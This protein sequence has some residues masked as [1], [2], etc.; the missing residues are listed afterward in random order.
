VAARKH[1]SFAMISSLPDGADRMDHILG[2][3]SASRGCNRLTRW[4][5]TAFGTNAS[6]LIC[7]ERTSCP[8]N[9]TANPTA[10][11]Q[12]GVGGVHNGV[13]RILGDVATYQA[14]LVGIADQQGY[15]IIFAAW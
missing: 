15:V 2:L 7:D 4:E 8:V 10:G 5:G 13:S 6:A 14:N 3:K 9:R 12:F 1:F 11:Q